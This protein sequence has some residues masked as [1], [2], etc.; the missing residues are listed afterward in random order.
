[1]TNLMLVRTRFVDDHLKR[2]IE[3]GAKQVVIL[4]AGFDTRAYRFAELLND[5]KVFEVDYRSTQQLKKTRLQEARI[6]V[7][8]YLRFVEI[9]FKKDVLADAL[10]QAGYESSLK[11]FLIWEGVSMYLSE[12]AE[13]ETLRT[14]AA[15]SASGSSLVMDFAGRAM[16]EMLNKFPNLSQ[17]NYTTHWGEP[18]TFGLPDTREREFF[19]ECGLELQEVLTFFGPEARKRYLTR[20]DGTTLG[21]VRGAPPRRRVFTTVLRMSWMLITRRSKWYALATLIVP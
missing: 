15:H 5:K 11:T 8:E 16:I 13:R 1:M 10:R 6:A 17:H 19:R 4:G 20:A 3:N 21:A 7:P 2:A 12:A 9:D 18:W 14:I